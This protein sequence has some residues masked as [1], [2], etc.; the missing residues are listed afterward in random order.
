VTGKA[1]CQGWKKCR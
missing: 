1:P